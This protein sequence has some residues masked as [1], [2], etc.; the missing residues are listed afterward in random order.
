MLASPMV[1]NLL[2]SESLKLATQKDA[3]KLHIYASGVTAYIYV[4]GKLKVNLSLSK[5][6]GQHECYLGL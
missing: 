4:G 5:N 6:V 3:S 2:K 1:R